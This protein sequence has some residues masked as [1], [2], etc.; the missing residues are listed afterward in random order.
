LQKLSEDEKRQAQ[1]DRE[2]SRADARVQ[3]ARKGLSTFVTSSTRFFAT[4]MSVT[5]CSANDEDKKESMA[6][7]FF[8]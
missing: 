1:A 2:L 5:S 6:L 3:Q 7:R 4:T 8:S